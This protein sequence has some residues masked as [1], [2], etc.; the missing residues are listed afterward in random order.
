MSSEAMAA[1][2]SV[3]L[4]AWALLRSAFTLLH[5]ISDRV[6]IGRVGRQEPDFGTGL[7]NQGDGALVLM[8]PEIVHHHDVAWADCV[9]QLLANPGTEALAIDGTIE[10]AG[11]DDPVAAQG[12]HEGHS[13]PVAMGRVAA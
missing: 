8:C 5:I 10:D 12:S 9:E 7:F 13:A 4:R 3:W 2:R 1:S 11:G 6:Q